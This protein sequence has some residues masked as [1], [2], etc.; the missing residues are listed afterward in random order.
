MGLHKVQSERGVCIQLRGKEGLRNAAGDG[1]TGWRDAMQRLDAKLTDGGGRLNF[2][3][4]R[5]D[6]VVACVA[7]SNIKP[8]QGSA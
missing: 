6:I 5:F 1:E 8:Q 3:I 7:V 2:S 4:E